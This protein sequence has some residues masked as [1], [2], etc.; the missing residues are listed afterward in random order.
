MAVVGGHQTK[1]P[2]IVA[3]E[4]AYRGEGL[5]NSS[6]VH[7]VRAQ[8]R[9]RLLVVGLV[10]SPTAKFPDQLRVGPS[11]GR[12]HAYQHPGFGAQPLD[13]VGAP[14]AGMDLNAHDMGSP[15]WDNLELG[16]D[17]WGDTVGHQIGQAFLHVQRIRHPD[18]PTGTVL[19]SD[20]QYATGGVRKG[21][22]RPE[23]LLGGTEITL[24]LQSRDSTDERV[25]LLDETAHAQRTPDRRELRHGRGPSG[26][27]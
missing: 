16:R 27:H 7:G 13:M 19:N 11:V 20:Q 8:L 15:P 9:K 26:R 1:C 6:E 21:H 3:A 14:R 23:N 17:V 10:P 24:G 2:E 25:D 18:H 12:P 4:L 5:G 22:D